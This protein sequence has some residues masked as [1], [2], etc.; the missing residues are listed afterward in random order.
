MQ[1]FENSGRS[2]EKLTNTLLSHR[3]LP[4]QIGSHRV[5]VSMKRV[6]RADSSG[7]AVMYLTK[8]LQR[9]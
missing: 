8:C 3:L 1:G 5:Q 6:I 2:S 7:N 9:L 4:R